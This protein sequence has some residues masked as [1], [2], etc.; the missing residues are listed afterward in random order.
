MFS[1]NASGASKQPK[2]Y[3]KSFKQEMFEDYFRGHMAMGEEVVG[4]V[5]Q[6]ET[7]FP[8]RHALFV[9]DNA[10]YHKSI[11]NRGFPSW[12]ASKTVISNYLLSAN[13]AVNPEDTK[14]ELLSKLRLVRATIQTNIENYALARG[15]RVVF[16]PPHY[17]W[18]QPIELYWASVK[19]DVARQYTNS[20][21]LSQTRE[22]LD[23]AIRARGTA[24]QCSSYIEHC[25]QKIASA[26]ALAKSA[27]TRADAEQAEL[28]AD[29]LSSDSSG[30]EGDFD[31]P[32]SSDDDA[33]DA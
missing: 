20:R 33:D 3:H 31:E 12:S 21:T 27:Q 30:S 29:V 18:W 16:T 7:A 5:E 22:Q 23:E 6:F 11:S 25:Y 10:T 15:H 32:S 24:K 14:V 26:W 17:S 19:G 4:M 13:V 9:M 28:V 8:G 2:D 1:P